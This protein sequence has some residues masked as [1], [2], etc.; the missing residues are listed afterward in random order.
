[1]SA[2]IFSALLLAG[3]A[4]PAA[5]QAAVDALVQRIY[6]PYADPAAPPA[7]LDAPIYSAETTGL[8]ARWKAVTPA[9]EPDRLSDGDWF[10]QCQ[11]WDQSAFRLTIAGRQP[12]PSGAVRVSVRFTLVAGTTRDARL[13]LVREGAD[14]RVDD[15]FSREMPR[16]FKQTIR[17]TIAEDEALAR[18]AAR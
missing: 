12:L 8:L 16:G 4:L 17:R 13:V 9:D 2:T 10:C 11:D 18:S 5:D 6:A 1:M 7:L 14:W 15:L 3:A